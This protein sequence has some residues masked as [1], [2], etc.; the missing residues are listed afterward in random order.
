MAKR[1]KVDTPEE[2]KALNEMCKTGSTTSIA[3]VWSVARRKGEKAPWDDRIYAFFAMRDGK[4]EAY[5]YRE[6]GEDQT[7][8]IAWLK[9]MPALN[10][11]KENLQRIE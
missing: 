1:F 4:R 7:R 2:L 11:C 10:W 3:K 5:I 9:Y 8:I 6:S